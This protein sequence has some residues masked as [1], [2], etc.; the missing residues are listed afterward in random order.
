M[1]SHHIIASAISL[2]LTSYP[3][4][5]LVSFNDGKDRF[6]VNGAVSIAYDSNIYAINGGQGDM[7]Y[8]MTYGAEYER[9]AGMLGV[10]ANVSATSTRFQDE[11]TEDFDNPTASLELTKNSGRT[12]GSL[13]TRVSRES[14]ADVEINTRSTS[15]N[16]ETGLNIRYPVIERYTV[17]GSLGYYE[18]DYTSDPTLVDLTTYTAAAD[19]FYVYNSERDLIGGYRFRYSDAAD[20]NTYSDHAFTLGL[21]GKILSKLNG[22]I[23][24][25]YQVRVPDAIG[26]GS[27][28]GLIASSAATWTI[29]KRANLTLSLLK[30]FTT[31][32]RDITVDATSGAMDLVYTLSTKTS[33]YSGVGG[34]ENRFIGRLSDA[35]RDEFFT[36]SI[37]GNY[38]WTNYLKSSLG[39]VHYKNWSNRQIS[40]FTRNAVTLTLTTRF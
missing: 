10:N 30:D 3:V 38:I 2:I 35:R 5:A 33:L 17:S 8:A 24:I 37:G 15:W 16:Y 28:S 19:I 4:K 26:E 34:G 11:Q 20:S 7:S 27:T 22:N 6:F 40:G 13:L 25:G 18:K 14:R 23:R 12:T 9:R 32:S 1:K 31:T 39:F 29:T 21:S 36:Y